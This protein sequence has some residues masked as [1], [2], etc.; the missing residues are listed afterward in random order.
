MNCIVSLESFGSQARALKSD[1]PMKKPLI[2]SSSADAPPAEWRALLEEATREVFELML[3]SKL[4]AST[5]DSIPA[6]EFTSMVGLAGELRGV[7]TLC[8][9]EK[10]AALMAS[11]ML[12]LAVE[13]VD[14]HIWDA[15]G[16]ITNMVAGNFKNKLPG[17]SERC[18]LSVPTVITGSSYTCHSMADAGSI[19]IQLQFLRVPVQVSLELHS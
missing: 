6:F 3:S 10:S 5:S 13:D 7:L 9:T 16:E 12:G 1:P 14:E 19:E 15:L 18:V 4:E 2:V 8:C 11:K 17:I